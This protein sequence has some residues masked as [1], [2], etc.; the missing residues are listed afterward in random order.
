MRSLFGRF[1][2]FF[3]LPENTPAIYC[4]LHFVYH[5][6]RQHQKSAVVRLYSEEIEIFN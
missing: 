5:L 6:D 2:L 4:I 3:D 1:C